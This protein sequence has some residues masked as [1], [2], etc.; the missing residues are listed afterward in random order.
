MTV[1]D[2]KRNP[3]LNVDRKNRRKKMKVVVQVFLLVLLTAILV[4]T[5]FDLKTYSEPDRA[6]WDQTEGF[7]AIS[8]FGVGRSGSSKL[9]AKSQL[10][11][12][13]KVLHEQGYVTISQQ[14][15]I[16]F[17]ERGKPLPK[18]A[19]FLSFEDGR[20]DSALFAQPI[21]EKY[22]GKATFLS[23]ANKMGASEGKFLQPKEMLKMEETGFWELGT[24]G[25]RLTYINIFDKDG[26]F[27]GVKDENELTDKSDVEYYNHYLMDFIRD[28]NMIP[29]ENRQQMEERIG[30]DYEL[31]RSVYTESLGYVPGTYMIMHANAL[32][33]GMNN[34]VRDANVSQIEDLFKLNFSREGS[35]WNTKDSGPH[36]LTR[37]QPAPYWSTN[38]LLMKLRKDTGE[39]LQFVRGDEALA[40]KWSL[41][42]G[43]A[44]FAGSQIIV[45]SPPSGKGTVYLN[46]SEQA[47][48]DAT[49]TVSATLLG[50][51]VGKQSIYIRHDR[52][53]S[54]Y[55]RVLLDNNVIRL[56]QKKEGELPK[57][58]FTYK[59]SDVKWGEEDL[60]FDKATVYSKAQTQSGARQD[61]PEYPINIPGK[62]QLE[63]SVTGNSVR[64]IADQQVILERLS[65]DPSI[66]T[67]GVALEA[68]YHEQNEKDDIYDAIFDQVTVTT[69]EL[70]DHKHTVLFTSKQTGMKGAAVKARNMFDTVVDWAIDNF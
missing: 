47:A 36:N 42:D 26:G 10:N 62:R 31:M 14:D 44:E 61:E 33:Q 19:L 50:N 18:R 58:L 59:L 21:L 54:S 63:V 15:I 30:A 23:Y 16:D 43:A 12:H 28:E 51:V 22:N 27:I 11:D 65:I 32:D 3:A 38:H 69:E 24:N 48:F 4:N 57:E 8:Y 53:K 46:G 25:Y 7:I 39:R 6:S 41:L 70:P 56:E 35:A 40:E 67:G 34:L 17:Y 9:V 37:V 45:T 64:I 2:N 68:Q 60:R 52:A 5:V 55:L 1:M 66:R 13:L 20:N 29:T 49:T